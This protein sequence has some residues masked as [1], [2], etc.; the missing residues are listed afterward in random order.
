MEEGQP[1]WYRASPCKGHGFHIAFTWGKPASYNWA[2][3]LSR[4]IWTN[5]IYFDTKPRNLYLLNDPK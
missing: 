3:S 5:Y 1:S 2:D 4:V